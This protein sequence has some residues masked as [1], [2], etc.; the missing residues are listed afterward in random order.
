MGNQP[1]WSLR[2]EK[3]V[4]KAVEESNLS[5]LK[6][7]KLAGIP[8][9]TFD[10]LMRGINPWNTEQLE[11]VAAALDMDPSEL[12]PPPKACQ[13]PAECHCRIEAS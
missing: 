8:N 3:R 5:N 6:V 11:R 9:S 13:A 7:A 12:M 1:R 4:R 2:I 10:R